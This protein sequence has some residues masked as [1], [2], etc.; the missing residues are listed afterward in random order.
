MPLVPIRLD[1]GGEGLD[2]VRIRRNA[3]ES[4][5]AEGKELPY[6]DL[7]AALQARVPDW[8]CSTV[9]I[10]PYADESASVRRERPTV[11]I[12]AAAHRSVSAW[13]Q[14]TLRP[15]AEKL[16]TDCGDVDAARD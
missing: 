1:R 9:R 12:K 14:L 7:R 13:C 15:W 11:D 16:G 8:C 6:A 3:K 5:R 4:G 2:L 10:L